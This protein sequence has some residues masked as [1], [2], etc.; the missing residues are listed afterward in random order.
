MPSNWNIGTNGP[1]T[2]DAL[3]AVMRSKVEKKKANDFISTKFDKDHIFNGHTGSDMEVARHLASL[4]GS[5][6]STLISKS[7]IASARKEVLNWIDN[8]LAQYLNFN[9]NV[10]T[11]S[12]VG[13]T[14]PS[15][16]TYKIA[17]VDLDQYKALNKD[18]K[19]KKARKWLTTTTKQVGVACHFDADG[20]PQIYHLNY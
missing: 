18:D 11:I 20:M 3:R 13:S 16:Q 8:I 9:T 14:V 4:R 6:L 19:V 17:T 10:W 1:T 5:A 2:V 15:V 12:T 7:I